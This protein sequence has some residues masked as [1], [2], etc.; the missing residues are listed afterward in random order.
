[1][2][3]RS[4]LLWTSRFAGW[5]ARST[6]RGWL[7]VARLVVLVALLL[8]VLPPLINAALD[9]AA[10]LGVWDRLAM[11]KDPSVGSWWT[12]QRVVLLAAA[13]LTL[14]WFVRARERVI[15]EEFV[16]Y[17]SKDATAVSGLAMLLVTEL[18]RLREL[19]GRVNEEL[20]TPLS[21]GVRPGGARESSSG[22][23]GAFLSVRADEVTEVLSGAVASESKVTFAGITIPIGVVLSMVGR[24]ARGPRVIG[25]VH[26][27][28]AG[29]GPT[30]TA[31]IVGR[32]RNFTWR[33]DAPADGRRAPDKAF[34]EPMVAEIACRM[35]TDMTLRGSVRW[36]AIQ[37]F[38]KYLEHYWESLRTP[39]NRASFLK[40]AEDR[41]LAAVAED[42]RF[43]LAFYNLGVVYS[44]LAQAEYLAAATAEYPKRKTSDPEAA[45]DARM[46][47]AR[48]AFAR[49]V[50]LNRG[51]WEAVY[52]LAVHEFADVRQERRETSATQSREAVLRCIVQRC[53]RVLEL[54]R[55]DG[56]AFDLMGMA[57]LELGQP[58]EAVRSHAHAVRRAWW[59]L[60]RT[61]YRERKKPP[62]TASVLPAA[63]ANAAAA[64]HNLGHARSASVKDRRP[65]RRRL[66]ILRADLVFH[67]ALSLAP[68]STKAA[69]EFDRGHA[70]KADD[71]RGAVDSYRAAVRIEPEN[72]VYWAYLARAL[73]AHADMRAEALQSCAVALE[74]LAPTYRRTLEPFCL[75]PLVASRDEAVAV[76]GKAYDL[77]ELPQ[78]RR[79]VEGLLDIAERISPPNGEPP[80]PRALED[81]LAETPED[82]WWRREQIGLAL[83]RALGDAGEWKMAAARYEWLIEN[84]GERRP[85]AIRQHSLHAKHAKALRRDGR[86]HE[87]L[88]SAARGLVLD[89]IS[90]VARREL[91]K[92]HFALLQY[93]EALE[94][95]QHTLWL[96]PNDATLHWKA[97]FS[98]WSTAQDYQDAGSR[99]QALAESTEAFE[100]AAMLFGIESVA[101]WA[102][103]RLWLGRV[104]HEMGDTDSA[105][106]HLRTA[107]GCAVAELPARVLLAEVHQANDQGGLAWEQLTKARRQLGAVVAEAWKDKPVSKALDR[108]SDADWGDTLS[109]REIAVRLHLGFGRHA[110]DVEGEER[111]ADRHAVVAERL[112][113]GLAKQARARNRLRARALELQSRVQLARD[114]LPAARETIR[115]AVHL[116]PEPAL[117]LRRIEI[118]AAAAEATARRTAR[119]QLV[120][121]MVD[122]LRA[123]RRAEGDTGER[124]VAGSLVVSRWAPDA[125]SANGNGAAG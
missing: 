112:A 124:A 91:G 110:L 77:L 107:K 37:A 8:L 4:T 69:M 40:L 80:G 26:L 11:E 6:S 109:Y 111:A 18:S 19:Y 33:I 38:T 72:P 22:E 34:L 88:A 103:S 61:E 50:A 81:L 52:A 106:K 30:L 23:P 90:P 115:R 48:T 63:Q 16:D 14:R 82:D 93:E 119:T 98:L 45:H 20:S 108:Y 25:S 104:A 67:Q 56:Q 49:A 94:A 76:L 113:G 29:G 84:L 27:T 1:M 66:G 73:A 39:K 24:I 54:H 71:R 117:L 10:A 46:T 51:R 120:A 21:V 97:A 123:I 65:L 79:R 100:R 75:P 87:A 55:W 12:W 83:A 96:T 86:K 122:D 17:T 105:M 78:E 32:G 116:A 68:D 64:L 85:E 43:D 70:R 53:E 62:T 102:W 36:Q 118:A 28:D 101:G 5:A 125:A 92:A 7:P 121:D 47:A 114:E 60:C 74:T 13:L 57:Q 59:R 44:Q 41:L 95:W 31:Q 3:F 42:E 15:V 99:Q 2:V 9:L 89:P 35:F 58:R